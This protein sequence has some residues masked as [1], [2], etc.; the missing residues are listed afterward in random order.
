MATYETE[1]GLVDSHPSDLV[2]ADSDRTIWVPWY[3]IRICSLSGA[4]LSAVSSE[5]MEGHENCGRVRL[6]T[7]GSVKH[8]FTIQD[9]GCYRFVDYGKVGQNLGANVFG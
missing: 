7:R 3:L 5:Q 8:D 9:D 1:F 6:G 4:F 2:T